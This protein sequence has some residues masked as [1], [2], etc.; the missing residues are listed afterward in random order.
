MHKSKS[1]HQKRAS[2]SATRRSS[3]RRAQA[4]ARQAHAKE[5]PPLFAMPQIVGG[6]LQSFVMPPLQKHTGRPYIAPKSHETALIRLE[7][8][9]SIKP[10]AERG[11][12][13]LALNGR[14]IVYRKVA[15]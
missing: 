15:A 3:K 13:V 7:Q 10:R 9:K 14:E 12:K 4:A 11:C 8:S 2:A 6:L 1:Y 5:T